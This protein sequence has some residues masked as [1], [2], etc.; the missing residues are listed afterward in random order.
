MNIKGIL[1]ICKGIIG[2]EDLEITD[3]N[4][5]ND[6]ILSDL[7]VC[8]WKIPSDKEFLIPE[9]KQLLNKNGMVIKGQLTIRGMLVLA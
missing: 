9:N 4:T 1:K 8:P 5:P 6:M 7:L 3:A 2:K